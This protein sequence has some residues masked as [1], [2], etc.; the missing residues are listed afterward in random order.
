MNISYISR[1]VGIALIFSAVFMF[2]SA[3]ISVYYDLETSFSPL[4]MSGVITLTVGLFPL[5]FV[6]K[7]GSIT[8]K[9]GYVTIVLSWLFS[10]ILGML[11]Y[12]LWGGEFSIIN[13][14]YESVSGFTTTGSTILNDIESLPKGL[15]FW[16]TSTHYI[17]GLG[18]VVFILLV[19]PTSRSGYGIKI[20]KV[21]IS[22]LSKENYKFKITEI[23]RVIIIVYL[24]LTIIQTLLLTLSGINFFDSLNH[25]MSIAA[26]GGFSTK[27]L[28]AA[29]FANPLAEVI[30]I[31]F[32]YLAGIHFGL[33]F[34]AFRGNAFSLF[35]NPVI[36]F[37]TIGLLIAIIISTASLLINGVETNFLSALRHS[38]FMNVSTASS[39]GFA[40]TQTKIW[41]VIG[42]LFLFYFSFQGACSGSTTGGLKVDRMCVWFSSLRGTTKRKLHSNAVVR[43]RLGNRIIDAETVSE[44]NIFIIFF[45]AIILVGSILL[46]ATGMSMEDSL[47]TSIACTGNTGLTFGSGGAFASYSS[48]PIVSKLIMTIEMFLGRLE[49]YPI[50]AMFAINK[51]K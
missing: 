12:V 23:A 17:G 37:Y 3:G 33:I 9:E 40:T 13:A 15:L 48:F 27:N 19:I 14:W 30:M 46:A 26:T 43:S 31:F 51:W 38:A 20:S 4:F 44:V 5:I 16:R 6:K 29:A 1:N 47:T 36:K 10:C 41:P 22:S 18:V 39:T 42:L 11:P 50:L 32:M 21:E 49:I 28:S 45:F 25:S 7:S 35:R 34:N 24:L 8:V 2:I